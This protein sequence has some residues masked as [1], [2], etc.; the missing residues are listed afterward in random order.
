MADPLTQIMMLMRPT[1]VFTKAIV[2]RGSWG[3]RYSDFGHPGFC[4]VMEGR[5]RLAVDGQ[6]PLTLETGDFVLLPATPGFILSGFDPVTPVFIDPKVAAT[7]EG[8][9][10]HGDPDGALG[11]RMLGGYFIFD[12]DDAGLL[13]SLLPAQIHVRGAERLSTLMR[14]LID[15]AGQQRAGRDLILSRLVEVMLVEALRT[16]QGADAPAGLLRGLGDAR[17]AEALRLMHGDPARSWTMAQL[18]RTTGFSRSVFFD[19]FTRN[20][21]VSPMEYLLGWRMALAKDLLRQGIDIAR[22]AEQIGYGSAS[23]FSVAFSRKVGQPPRRYA[24]ATAGA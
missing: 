14:L 20:L 11:A 2:G 16:V 17:L 3:V 18:A 21:G 15:E 4:T 13:V 23:A 8:E 19:R 1:A 24:R 10:R 5:C 6:A 12:T 9:A 7:L 22:I